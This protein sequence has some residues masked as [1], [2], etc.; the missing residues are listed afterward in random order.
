M[1]SL[2]TVRRITGVVSTDDLIPARYKHMYTAPQDLAPHLLES[3]APQVAAAL[4][5]GDVLVSDSLFGIGSSREQAVTALRAV[6]VAMV[7]APSFGR[8]LFRNCWNLALPAIELDTS[9][10]IDGSRI[11]IDLAGGTVRLGNLQLEFSRPPGFLLDL[12]QSGGLLNGLR[13]P[14]A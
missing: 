5:P 2:H 10:F 9:R 1:T 8:I 13:R 12:V 6:G 4:R 11:A 14:A 3:Y 7:F